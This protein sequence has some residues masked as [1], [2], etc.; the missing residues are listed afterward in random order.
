MSFAPVHRIELAHCPATAWKNG[1]GLTRELLTWRAAH[2]AGTQDDPSHWDLRVSVADIERDGPFSSFP[3]IDRGF[4]VLQ[5]AGVVLSMA[6]PEEAP[7]QDDLTVGPAGEALRFGGEL[8]VGCQLRD[9][10]TRDLNFM[11]R[12]ERGR[13]HMMRASPGSCWGSGLLWKGIFCWDAGHLQGHLQG[14]QAMFD[15]QGASLLWCDDL[16]G[17]C[18][19][20]IWHS[21][22]LAYWLGWEPR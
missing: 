2:S 17:S 7:T 18:G 21:E 6:S 10:P 16:Q 22:G 1:G 15:V 8:R 5:G 3:G 19:D 13:L 14:H 11:V 20:F 12:R 4:A 9:G